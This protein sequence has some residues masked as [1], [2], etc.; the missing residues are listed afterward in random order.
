MATTDHSDRAAESESSDYEI[1]SSIEDSL[2]IDVGHLSLK[3]YMHEP[4][5]QSS[6]LRKNVDS[7]LHTMAIESGGDRQR[8]TTTDCQ[9]SRHYF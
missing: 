2:G 7:L 1:C 4:Q 6:T 8:P 3:P 9:L 5:A